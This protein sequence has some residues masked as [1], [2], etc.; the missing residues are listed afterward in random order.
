MHSILHYIFGRQSIEIHLSTFNFKASFPPG[1]AY[2]KEM[3]NLNAFEIVS[4]IGCGWNLGNSLENEKDET[5][6]GNPI[7][8]KA[9]IDKIHEQGFSSL[10]VPVAWNQHYKDSTNYIIWWW[11]HESSWNSFKLWPF[12]WHACYC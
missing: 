7:T 3:R 8:T 4:E 10:R 11:F 1:Y 12:Q 9:M 5:T 2:P 6:M